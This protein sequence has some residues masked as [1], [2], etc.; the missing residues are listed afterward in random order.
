MATAFELAYYRALT[1][2]TF[3]KDYVRPGRNVLEVTS[4]WYG[5]EF[6]GLHASAAAQDDLIETEADSDFICMAIAGRARI[7]ATQAFDSM[8][9]IW[10]Q[11]TD[12]ASGKTF[13]NTP[14][15]MRL[16]A[17]DF[18]M[19][20]AFPIPRVVMPNSTLQFDVQPFDTRYDSCWITLGGVRVFYEAQL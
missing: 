6:D 18:G 5:V 19:P 7:Q 8:P 1:Q 16:V 4:F 3:L 14:L 20:M 9:L 10:C 12:Q 13:F 17:G 15:I 11:V 2:D